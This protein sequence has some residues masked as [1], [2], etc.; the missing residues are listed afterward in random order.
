L[1]NRNKIIRLDSAKPRQIQLAIL[2]SSVFLIF[3][4]EGSRNFFDNKTEEA[5]SIIRGELEPDTNIVIIHISSADI[6]N[7]GPWPIKRSYYALLIKSLS[8]YGVKKIGLEI[9]LSAK[10]STQAIY[11]NLLRREIEKSGRV[12]LSSVAGRINFKNGIYTTDSLSFPTPKLLNEYITTGHINYIKE[13]NIGIPAGLKGKKDEKAFAVQL[14]EIKSESDLLNINFVSSWKRVKN[15]TLL[16]YFK[17]VEQ[18]SEKL[19]ALKNKIVLIGL[20]DPELAPSF[21]S[22]F[23][24]YLPGVAL[25]AFTADN[26]LNN[27]FLKTSLYLPSLFFF[28]VV[29]LAVL[30]LKKIRSLGKIIFFY[31]AALL[32]FLIISFA[33]YSYL[34]I[35]LAYSV[36]IVPLILLAVS[37]LVFHLIESKIQLKG[38]I[39]E[40]QFLKSLLLKK[41]QELE[42]V[43][44]ELEI[45]ENQSSSALLDKIKSLKED[46]G[47]LKEKETDKQEAVIKSSEEVKNFYGIIYKSKIMEKPVE[48]IKKAAPG[49]AN[50]LL[51]GETGTGKELAAKA[52][53]LLSE[54]KDNNFIAVNCGA[55]SDTL[56]ESELFG[57]VK[58]SFTGAL[59]D[60]AGRFEAA[61]KGTIF[62]DEIAETSENFQVKLLRV[63]QSGDFEKVGSSKTIHSDIRIIAATNK[64]LTKAVRERKFREDLYYRLNVIKIELPP[65]RERK[66]DIEIL[67]VHFIE[68][69]SPG[70]KLSQAAAEALNKFEWR[71]NVR[72]LEAAM[73]RAV[74]FAKSSGRNLIRLQDLPDEIVKDINLNFEELILES[75]RKKH[76]SH[77]SIN[78]TAEELGLSRT[79]ISENFR[80]FTFKALVENNY[81]MYAAVN[82]ISGTDDKETREKVHSKAERFLTNVESDI[83]KIDQGDFQ[84]IKNKLASKYKNLPQK[85]HQYL[86]EIIKSYSE[87]NP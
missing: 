38:V 47:R 6:E 55:L 73:K 46:I 54:K 86:D 20:S 12:V 43:Q 65:L 74:I 63:I 8:N 19:A 26:L 44:K 50:I 29:L 13:K 49:D 45:T 77:S 7:I 51:I 56:L 18:Q 61:D 34:H 5:F 58:G 76:F 16:E 32:L 69:E 28:S 23:D 3:F 10:F 83:K 71:G 84:Y 48:L 87:K 40:A 75:L 27:R 81:N 79:I 11:D 24:G 37:D 67:A 53:H 22:A 66:E 68:S 15:Y 42:N 2:I 30:F 9:F 78:E 82:F 14:V 60:K 25:H 35:Q 59:A 4:M 62:L 33:V 41:E 64:D 21:N 70:L 57:H 36:F 17:M 85:F 1:K 80:G 52:I 39:D 31:S 72:Q